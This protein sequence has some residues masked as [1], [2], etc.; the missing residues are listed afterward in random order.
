MKQKRIERRGLPDKMV[1]ISF[2]NPTSAPYKV[3]STAENFESCVPACPGIGCSPPVSSSVVRCFKDLYQINWALLVST[4]HYFE[5]WEHHLIDTDPTSTGEL[6]A[7][8]RQEVA[9]Y[10]RSRCETYLRTCWS[11]WFGTS[12]VVR[13]LY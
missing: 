12:D 2:K 13:T 5:D 6:K 10:P 4:F 9:A 7:T 3:L 11:T 8:V 1:T